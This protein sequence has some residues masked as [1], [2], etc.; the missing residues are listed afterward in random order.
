MEILQVIDV[1][2]TPEGW[3]IGLWRV[4]EKARWS[5]ELHED[6]TPVGGT[7]PFRVGDLYAYRSSDGEGEMSQITVEEV[8]VALRSSLPVPLRSPGRA[9][10]PAVQS[11]VYGI[12]P[13]LAGHGS[14]SG[15]AQP[16]AGRRYAN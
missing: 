10:E 9:R 14:E 4:R 15:L 13:G 8:P 11:G 3:W 5:I 7:S 16:R 12:L 2:P 6:K 1:V